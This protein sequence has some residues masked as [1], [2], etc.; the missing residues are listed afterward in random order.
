MDELL[1]AT[2]PDHALNLR[3][4]WTL[5][6]IG[7]LAGAVLGLGFHRGEFLGGY[8]SWRRR[9]L[10]LG[11]V[12]L[13]ALGALNVLFALTPCPDPGSTASALAGT[14]LLVGAVAMPTTCG[15]A[16]WKPAFRHA[17]FVPVLA[18]LVAVV[19]TLLHLP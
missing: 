13:V 10:R 2:G 11:H 19:A 4:G 14:A 1:I 6:L 5:I 18:L 9:L 16:A 8:S 17:F 15:L 3:A 7:F 12:A